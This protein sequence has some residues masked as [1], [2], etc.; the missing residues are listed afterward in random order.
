MS[1]IVSAEEMIR[2]AK[3]SV[4]YL[5]DDEGAGT[6]F[7]ISEQGH[8]LTC[9]HVVPGDTV[10]A[11]S[12]LG[13][14]TA[15]GVLARDLDNDLAILNCRIV[16]ARPLMFADPTTIAEGQTVFAL[17]HPLGLDFTVS[18]GV[19]SSVNRIIR[20]VSFLQTDV[21]LNP[22]NSGG[23]IVNESGEVVGIADWG[24]AEGRGLGFAVSVRHVLGF[25]AQVRVP[26]VRSRA[27][28][29]ASFEIA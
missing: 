5:R 12:N 10:Q 19:V 4:V 24:F 21:P 9:N 17:G 22:G 15:A 23:P 7:F 28:S 16:G 29:I 8:I 1:D 25:T 27:F 14:W 20:G 11:R 3:P 13:D 18:R 2:A 26:V 6:G